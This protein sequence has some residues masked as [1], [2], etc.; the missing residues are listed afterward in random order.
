MAAWD[1]P[2]IPDMLVY[3][4]ISKLNSKASSLSTGKEIMRTLSNALSIAEEIGNIWNTTGGKKEVARLNNILTSMQSSNVG[5][6][7]GMLKEGAKGVHA[8]KESRTH[9]LY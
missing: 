3:G 9:S 4:Q 5:T 6:S 1:G 8:D 7:I 2:G